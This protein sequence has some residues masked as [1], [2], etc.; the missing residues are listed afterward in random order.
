MSDFV[1][2]RST[3]LRVPNLAS[4]RYIIIPSTF[5][6]NQET[7]YL[8]RV[9][10]PRAAEMKRLTDDFPKTCS[11]FRCLSWAKTY[12]NVL[13]IK[14]VKATDL[15]VLNILYLIVLLFLFCFTTLFFSGR[16]SAAIS[17]V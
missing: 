2:S 5:R 13:R 9:Y 16:I 8:L 17:F 10:S 1:N 12:T 11:L 6:P 14:V 15:Q 3:C 4:G 7:N